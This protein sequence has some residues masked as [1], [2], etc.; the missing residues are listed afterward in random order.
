MGDVAA[1]IAVAVAIIVA[2]FVGF[3]SPAGASAGGVDAFGKGCFSRARSAVY[4]MEEREVCIM[5]K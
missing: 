4:F 2:I 1:A 3:G 5:Y